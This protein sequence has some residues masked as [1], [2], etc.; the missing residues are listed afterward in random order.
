MR[1]SR[2]LWLQQKLNFVSSINQVSFSI[3]LSYL[4]SIDGIRQV[5]VFD[6]ASP[7][8]FGAILYIT[9]DFQPSFVISKSR[10]SLVKGEKTFPQLELLAGVI[11]IRVARLLL[12]PFHSLNISLELTFWSDKKKVHNFD[13]CFLLCCLEHHFWH[14]RWCIELVWFIIFWL[15]SMCLLPERFFHL[16]LSWVG[17]YLFI[18]YII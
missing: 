8:A 13:H 3:L 15:L 4:G 10:V 7:H 2:A 9:N 14:S 18:F 6:D 11:K 17:V 5:H 12:Q 1:R 16:S